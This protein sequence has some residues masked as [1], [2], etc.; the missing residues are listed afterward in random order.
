LG[1]EQEQ[2]AAELHRT[3]RL[4]ERISMVSDIHRKTVDRDEP[5]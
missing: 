3:S 5:G 4:L 2:R 1:A